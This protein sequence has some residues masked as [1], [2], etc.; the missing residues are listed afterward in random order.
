MPSQPG[1]YKL[2]EWLEDPRTVAMFNSGTVRSL[3]YK[4]TRFGPNILKDTAIA[5]SAEWT[6]TE[7]PTT[8]DLPTADWSRPP[9]PP[10]AGSSASHAATPPCGRTLASAACAAVALVECRCRGS[11]CGSGAV[12]LRAEFI[13]PHAGAAVCVMTVA[14]VLLSDALVGGLCLRVLCCVSG[15]LPVSLNSTD[16]P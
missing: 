5:N 12:P 7:L 9:T 11:L 3:T 4:A 1:E 14:V 13:V 8:I 16:I 2:G 15:P 6:P 10:D